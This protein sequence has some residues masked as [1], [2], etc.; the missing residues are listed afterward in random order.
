MEQ[1]LILL[2]QLYNEQDNCYLYEG[3]MYFKENELYNSIV[4][5]C[6]DMLITN[7]GTCNWNNMC[8]LIAN[9]YRVFPGE[10][11]SFGWLTGCIRKNDDRRIVC[12]G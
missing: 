11:D 9:G 3:R 5:I 7:D 1:L 10:K 8:F 6:N 2:E 4:D 12:F